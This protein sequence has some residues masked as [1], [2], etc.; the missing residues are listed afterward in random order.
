MGYTD[1]LSEGII[2]ETV[3]KV[4][5]KQFLDSLENKFIDI[6]AFHRA[7]GS[8][9][10]AAGLGDIFGNQ[11]GLLA[12]RGTYG[13]IKNCQDPEL[14]K[15]LKKLWVAQYSDNLTTKEM[16]AQRDANAKAMADREAAL[17]VEREAKKEALRKEG[18]LTADKCR[19]AAI[20]ILINEHKDVAEKY[21]ELTGREVAEDITL[22]AEP[23][24]QKNA[25]DY[26][27]KIKDRQSFY[28]FSYDK[29]NDT[30]Y[31]VKYMIIQIEDQMK[32]I[33]NERLEAA[34]AEAGS[35]M[36]AKSGLTDKDWSNLYFV[37]KTT[38]NVYRYGHYAGE[39]K[40]ELTV[41]SVQN[42]TPVADRVT[43]DNIPDIDNLELVA[44]SKLVDYSHGRCWY[45]STTNL[46]Y[47]PKYDRHTL[48]QC[49]V[50]FEPFEGGFNQPSMSLIPDD[51]I[52]DKYKALGF[53][54]GERHD[55]EY[56]SSD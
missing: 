39:R 7:Y 45:S 13:K 14:Q 3:D 25:C 53:T 24:L 47:N 6:D 28:R 48:E 34:Y 41:Y 27:L 37:D 32:N 38:N 2:T 50:C 52:P 42:G 15:G 10:E 20:E 8:A 51:K 21:K 30:A 16:Q 44:F 46:F 12:S 18:Q 22:E 43:Y 4:A 5:E 35:V 9:I 11:E 17:R 29:I 33:A 31:L 19:A 23:D 36:S 54:K 55:S 56:D 26:A 40:N 49:G 1:A